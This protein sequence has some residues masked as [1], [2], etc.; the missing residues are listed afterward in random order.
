M[1]DTFLTETIIHQKK[2]VQERKPPTQSISPP[3]EPE[4]EAQKK[5]RQW[6]QIIKKIGFPPEKEDYYN[7]WPI[8]PGIFFYR[9]LA[10]A[11][12]PTEYIKVNIPESI[13]C[14]DQTYFFMYTDPDTGQLMKKTDI[15]YQDF[16]QKIAE[17]H[18]S[19]LSRNQNDRKFDDRTH[20]QVHDGPYIIVRGQTGQ[21]WNMSKN[22]ITFRQAKERKATIDNNKL[23]QRF[24][25]SRALKATILRLVYY[26]KNSKTSIANFGYRIMNL[27]DEFDPNPKKSVT[28][29][30][31]LNTEQL[32]S[33]T[34]QL[35][36]GVGLKDYERVSDQVVT[37]LERN[38]PIRIKRAVFDF[39]QDP[40]NVIWL[41]NCKSL[42]MEDA[43]SL[44]EIQGIG[45][46]KMDLDQLICSVYCKLCGIIF[47]KD[48]ASKTLTYK[49]LWELVQH[50]KKRNKQLKDIKVSHLS[51]RPCRVCD[52][53]Y[54][55]IVGEHELVEIEQKF[56]MAQNIPLGDAI[57]RVPMDSKPKHRPALLSEQLYQWRLLFFFDGVDL[58]GK[59]IIDLNGNV[60]QEIKNMHVQY[61]LYQQKTFF[62][63]TVVNQEKQPKQIQSASSLK[64]LRF[65]G[66]DQDDSPPQTPQP[67]EQPQ[68]LKMNVIRVHY[69]FS[70][71][72]DIEKFLSE[73][74]IKMRLTSG[75]E[76]VNY[77]AEGSTKTIHHFKNHQIGGQRHS[78][79][80]LL[81]FANGQYCTLNFQ[82]GLVCDGQYNTGKLNLYKHNNVYFPDDN[83]YNCNPFP[84]EWMEMFDPES[85][86]KHDA[87]EEQTK[88]IEAY[89]P[90][91]TKNELNQMIDFNKYKEQNKFQYVTSKIDSRK[92]DIKSA[93]PA[94]NSQQQLLP[95]LKPISSAKKYSSQG[96]SLR[97]L[98]E[99]FLLQQYT[100]EEENAADMLFEEKKQK[101]TEKDKQLYEQYNIYE[102]MSDE[103]E[104]ANQ[105][106]NRQIQSAQGMRQTKSAQQLPPKGRPKLGK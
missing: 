16:E 41:I 84:P 54:M 68:N 4:S 11:R 15:A 97:Q 98:D 33:F 29:K 50:L 53:C 55:L 57:I 40:E 90:K 56:A 72:I 62:K 5:Q 31:C 95:Q 26:T 34:I 25:V 65:H 30:S 1:A 28:N 70:E 69:F 82:V 46:G 66:I 86:N 64:Q 32:G 48:D 93:A 47:K 87:F 42:E 77:V 73:T 13:M 88:E 10:L 9:A 36:K 99:Q 79:Q 105:K 37:F 81:F 49:L 6:D 2:K 45:Q 24:V 44:T 63:T 52:V 75:S 83:Y 14:F 60:V 67:Q 59:K 103:D 27:L 35:V 78:S 39:I 19:Y 61:K 71:T 23:E 8:R 104:E 91:C 20:V 92:R 58:Q 17:Y 21:D 94:Y 74:E 102:D 43:I 7:R 18:E 76:W 106:L 89:S 38:Y 96:L 85:V 22:V 100:V 12:Q 3:R 51:T 80:C 101:I